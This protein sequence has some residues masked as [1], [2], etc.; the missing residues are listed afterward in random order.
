MALFQ[1]QCLPSSTRSILR[2]SEADKLQTVTAVVQAHRQLVQDIVV[3]EEHVWSCSQD[4]TINICEKGGR[5]VKQIV[6]HTAAVVSLVEVEGEI[7]SASQDKSIIVWSSSS[8]EFIREI[9]GRHEEPI[10]KLLLH[11]RKRH[12]LSASLDR[13]ICAWRTT[14]SSQ[15]SQAPQSGLTRRVSVTMRNTT[16]ARVRTEGL[17]SAPRRVCVYV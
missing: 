12:V 11:P 5:Q 15:A 17:Y 16:L 3:T 9:K 8:F 6:G 10:V 2:N 4:K 7:W 13:T 1:C 14:S